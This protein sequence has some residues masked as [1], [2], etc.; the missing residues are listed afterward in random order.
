MITL[1]VEQSVFIWNTGTSSDHANAYGID[2]EINT[3]SV[4]F[5]DLGG[6]V[7]RIYYFHGF[8]ASMV[9]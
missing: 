5:L 4:I 9:S 7:C 3:L 2:T 1:C 8:A 6:G